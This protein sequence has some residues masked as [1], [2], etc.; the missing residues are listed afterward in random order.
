[1]P[2]E[3]IQVSRSA[4]N[5]AKLGAVDAIADAYNKLADSFSELLAEVQE[6]SPDYS[7]IEEPP[8][9]ELRP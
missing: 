9:I 4:A 1:M 8:V 3:T 7:E 2:R 6:G 5:A